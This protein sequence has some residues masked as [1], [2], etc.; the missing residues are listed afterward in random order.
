MSKKTNTAKR[1]KPKRPRRAAHPLIS[2]VAREIGYMEAYYVLI[3]W[4]TIRGKL[5]K[6]SKPDPA[7]KCSACGKEATEAYE[8]SMGMYCPK[9][10]SGIH[11][12]DSPPKG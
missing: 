9:T 12:F 3:G 4:K 1:Q 6:G 11:L 10:E 2:S 7:A 8:A 5:L